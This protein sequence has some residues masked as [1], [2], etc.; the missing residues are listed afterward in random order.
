M[1]AFVCEAHASLIVALCASLMTITVHAKVRLLHHCAA[2]QTYT[3]THAHAHTNTYILQW[4][5]RLYI[6]N[7]ISQIWYKHK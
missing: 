3:H 2:A 1:A 6:M 5:D 7:A 4:Q